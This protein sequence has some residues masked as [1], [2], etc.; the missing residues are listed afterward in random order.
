L[1]ELV[2]CV[3]ELGLKGIKLHPKGQ[4]FTPSNEFVLRILE[5]ASELDVPVIFDNGKWEGHL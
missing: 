5:K 2:R 3:S 4:N 1:E